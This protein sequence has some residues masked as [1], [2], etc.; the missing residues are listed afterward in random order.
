MS[1]KSYIGYVVGKEETNPISVWIPA[2][3]GFANMGSKKGFGS[4]AGNMSLIDLADAR[5]RSEKCYITSEMSSQGPYIYDD[6]NGYSTKE[7]NIAF[8]D[9][10]T[11]KNVKDKS[12]APNK[13]S[14]PSD[15][16]FIKSPHGS[17]AANF[18]QIFYPQPIDGTQINLYSNSPGGNFS[19]LSIGTKVMVEFPDGKG[20]GYITRQIPGD[21]DMSRLLKTI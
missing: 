17:P 10:N 14:A 5:I 15:G 1:I 21:D 13:Y 18:L 20:V 3:H 6:T 4:N 19:L 9:Q 16:D 11:A 12:F 8:L 2:K 7:D